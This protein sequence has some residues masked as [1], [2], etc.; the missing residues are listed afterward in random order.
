M[1]LLTVPPGARVHA[2]KHEARETGIY[3]LS[4]EV[5]LHYG[6]RPENHMV[7]RASDFVYI[8]ATMPHQPY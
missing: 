3:V 7:S 1:Q 5:G 6:A 8:P 2:H 4:G